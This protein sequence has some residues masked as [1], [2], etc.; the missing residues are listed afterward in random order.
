MIAKVSSISGMILCLALASDAQTADELIAKNLAAR[1]GAE[2]LRAVQTMLIHGTISFGDASS[3]IEVKA[4]RPGRIREEFTVDG[5]AMT[6]AYDGST[7]WTAQKKGDE[8][9]VEALS[10][11]EADNIRE[12]AE[13]AIEGPLLDYAKKGSKVDA[14]G[15]DTWDGK[16]VYKLKIT[17]HM[18]TS[19]VQFLDS[20]TY[21][22]IHEE[23]ERTVDGKLMVIVEDVGDYRDVSGIKYAHRFVS[24]T[25]ENPKAN[26]FQVEK[27]ELNAPVDAGLFA[28]PGQSQK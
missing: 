8:N 14:L 21:L 4:Q 13:N 1:G 9:K 26:T 10:G 16:P 23:I 15:R 19:I 2:K 7:G 12:E 17:T 3:P 18:A 11:G 27:M 22:E 24:G 25:E 28:M 5:T 20:A 6:R